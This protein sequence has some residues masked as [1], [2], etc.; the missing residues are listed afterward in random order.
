V[1]YWSQ[2]CRLLHGSPQ[3]ADE[4]ARLERCRAQQMRDLI[5]SKRADLERACARARLPPPPPPPGF[6][7]SVAPGAC[8]S[9]AQARPDG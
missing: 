9:P 3:C 2:L 1:S 6:E 5:A 7:E 4:V 8:C